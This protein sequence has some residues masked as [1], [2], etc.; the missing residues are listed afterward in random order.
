MNRGKRITVY[1]FCVGRQTRVNGWYVRASA[2]V[3]GVVPA[4]TYGPTK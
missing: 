2:G 1:C 3:S 4:P